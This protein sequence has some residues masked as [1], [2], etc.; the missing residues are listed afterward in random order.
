[1]NGPALDGEGILQD[2][3]DDLLNGIADGADPFDFAVETET[4]AT[5]PAVN[6]EPSDHGG[7]ADGEDA[8]G[9]NGHD[10]AERPAKKTGGEPVLDDIVPLLSEKEAAAS[11]AEIDAF[12]G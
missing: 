1:M 2:Q 9:A 8:N 6:P 12:F 5:G 10:A 7:P 3:V 11:Q 4:I